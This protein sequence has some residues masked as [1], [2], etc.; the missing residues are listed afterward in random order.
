MLR[1]MGERPIHARPRHAHEQ[2]MRLE[3]LAHLTR[4]RMIAAAGDQPV[5]DVAARLE[6]QHAERRIGP[7][8]AARELCQ[9]DRRRA[10]TQPHQLVAEFGCA[11][12]LG[13]RILGF[14]RLAQGVD[15]GDDTKDG[16]GGGDHHGDHA[17]GPHQ[18]RRRRRIRRHTLRHAVHLHTR[19]IL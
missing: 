10:N 5:H 11:M 4:Q 1:G 2:R 3:A 6:A 14:G 16:G 15:R 8:E 7:D 18:P 13:E 19:A 12:R 9:D 17:Q